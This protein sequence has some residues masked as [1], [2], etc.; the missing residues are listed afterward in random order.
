VGERTCRECKEPIA[1]QATRCP[2]CTAR[3]DDWWT[4]T[5]TWMVGLVVVAAVAGGVVWWNARQAQ[6]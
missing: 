2:H 6:Q 1:A 5:S 3:Q 4:R